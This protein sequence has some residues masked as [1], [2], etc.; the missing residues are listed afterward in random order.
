MNENLDNNTVSIHGQSYRVS[1]SLG[2]VERI[3]QEF[4]VFLENASVIGEEATF[5]KLAFT[6][7]IVN[8]IKHGCN[9]DE[10]QKVTVSWMTIGKGIRLEV[11]DPGI[12]PPE[13]K[14][15]S[16]DLPKD[17]FTSHG[18]GLYLIREFADSWQHWH[19]PEGYRLVIFKNHPQLTEV[20]SLEVVLENAIED[21]SAS[22][23]NLSA[24]YQLGDGLVRSESIE[25]FIT[26]AASDLSVAV[27]NAN[28]WF[29]FGSEVDSILGD[30][31]FKESIIFSHEHFGKIPNDVLT[32]GTEFIWESKN[33]VSTDDT[34]KDYSCGAC[35]PVKAS[36]EVRG[37]LTVVRESH[38]PFNT[39]ELNTLRTFSDI[40]GIAVLNAANTKVRSEEA[41]AFREL[42][43]ASEIQKT[44]LPLP[45]LEVDPRWDI[46]TRRSNAR[47]VA[48]DYVDVKQG[49]NGELYLVI[50][51]VMGKG[52]SAAFLAA[53]FRTALHIS[54]TFQYSLPGLMAA[55]NRTLSDQLGKLT[56]FATCAIVR[57]A[58]KLDRFEVVN[59]G[60]CPV[61]L[62]GPD[63]KLQL[64][65]ASGPP[66][67]L[68]RNAEYTSETF[69]IKALQRILL[70]TDGLFEWS[71]KG[72]VW[73]WN[74]LCS[75]VRENV[76]LNGDEL[77]DKIQ[78]EIL[79]KTDDDDSFTDDRTLISWSLNK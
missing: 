53:M 39:G 48:G 34:L 21:L 23:E 24:F 22:Y 72:K 14:V 13:S 32:H 43:I 1:A 28:V 78:G 44:L 77:W 30:T 74:A 79:E 15:A 46:V 10:K 49:R 76:D 37:V 38:S 12:G 66:L 55:L 64:S 18:R 71:H 9:E 20:D 5:W 26:Q 68:F 70:V 47:E 41:R 63:G 29:I 19:G 35:C 67:G 50:V 7:A 45:S 33:E 58:P 17:P 52:V 59:A 69:S 61:I 36:G 11:S 73:G 4:T 60:H 57:I 75:F 65:K 16:P 40:V 8:A 51:D 54:L 31:L 27:P 42:E 56:M 3:R 2:E 6:E 25:A 62:Y